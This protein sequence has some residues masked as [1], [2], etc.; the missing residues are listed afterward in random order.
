MCIE[1]ALGLLSGLLVGIGIERKCHGCRS[2]GGNV[3]PFDPKTLGK[4]YSIVSIDGCDYIKYDAEHLG[5][6]RVVALVHKGNC[7]NIHY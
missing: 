1:F 7:R 6:T 2:P 5:E 3:K 4:G